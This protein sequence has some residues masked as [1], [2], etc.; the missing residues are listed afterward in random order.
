MRDELGALLNEEELARV[1]TPRSREIAGSA[2][3]PR[4]RVAIVP[5]PGHRCE[6]ARY[7]WSAR[8]PPRWGPHL[9]ASPRGVVATAFDDEDPDATVAGI[10]AKLDAT[11]PARRSGACRPCG[12]RWR[13]TSRAGSG[14]FATAPD[15]AL[16]PQ[17]FGR[18]VLEVTTTI[19]YGELWTYGD[20]AEMAGSPRGGRAAGN[21]PESVPHGAVRAVPP[22]GPRRRH[23]GRLRALHRT[24]AMVA[25]TRGSR[26]S[27]PASRSFVPSCERMRAMARIRPTAAL[28]VSLVLMAPPAPAVGPT[29][30][31][32]RAP[33]SSAASTSP[34][35][36]S[37]TDFAVDRPERV[38]VGICLEHA[39]HRGPGG[40]VRRHLRGLRLPGTRRILRGRSRAVHHLLLPPGTDD[41]RRRAGP[42][43]H[44]PDRCPRRVP[45][46]GHPVRPGR[47]SG[48]PRSTRTSTTVGPVTLESNFAVQEQP[49]LPAPGQGAATENLTLDSKG[50]K[51]VAID[52]RAQDGEPVPDPELH[53]WTIADAIDQAAA[54]AR[55]VRHAGLLHQP[56]LRARR[57]RRWSNWRPTIPTRPC[58]STSR[59]GAD[60]DKSEIRTRAR[61]IGCIATTT[62]PSPGST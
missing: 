45:S 48:R 55:P 58:S 39:G 26:V 13:T 53:G 12:G 3:V 40:H 59:S 35:R 46:R 14:R 28:V 60:Y 21:G 50:V 61:R 44:E 32:P 15:L 29:R 31:R 54:R 18:R 16:A 30:P 10:E 2:R 7:S 23:A 11:V 1:A 36:S 20:V 17:G 52:S 34:R 5:S 57:S 47:G 56:V 33:T 41:R 38:Q 22:S 8:S 27:A 43:A 25:P 9:V 4:A 24:Q 42:R 49:A 19:P 62:S 51:P 6:R 37:P